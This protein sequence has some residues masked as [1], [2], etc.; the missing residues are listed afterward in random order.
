MSNMGKEPLLS[1]VL[2]SYNGSKYIRE[3]IDSILTQTYK[4]FEFIIWNDGSTD[5]TE[6][7]IKSYT[8]DRIRYFYHENTGLGEALRLACEKARGKYIARMDDDDISMPERFEKEINFLE[9]NTDCVLVSSAVYFI[10]ENGKITGRSFPCTDKTVLRCVIQANNMIVHPMVMMRIEAYRKAGGYVPVRTAQD[11]VTWSRLSK[12]GK[13]A[14]IPSPLGKYRL[15]SSS[16]SHTINPYFMVIYELRSKMIRD[17]EILESDVQ[18]YNELYLYS[19][20]HLIQ[21]SSLKKMG[22]KGWDDILFYILSPVIGVGTTER[23]ISGIKNVY[24]R[25]KYRRYIK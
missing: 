18:K 20:Q 8:D 14:N 13:F 11:R 12:Y 1:V 6:E 21:E 23:M 15:L 25:Y 4:D 17:E 2:C 10:D 16:I 9:E 5:S 3:A 19:K 7:I 22:K 24:F